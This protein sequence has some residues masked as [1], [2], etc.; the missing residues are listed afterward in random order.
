MSCCEG[1]IKERRDRVDQGEGSVLQKRGQG[2][3]VAFV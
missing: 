1:P 2:K 3:A